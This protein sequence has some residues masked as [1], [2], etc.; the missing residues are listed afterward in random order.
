MVGEWLASGLGVR[1]RRCRFLSIYLNKLVYDIPSCFINL[2]MVF[3]LHSNIFF[4]TQKMDL[5]C[6]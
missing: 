4:N 2:P 1:F 6:I 5:Y 3:F